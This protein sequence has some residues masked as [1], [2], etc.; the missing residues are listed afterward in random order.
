MPKTDPHPRFKKDIRIKPDVVQ[1]PKKRPCSITGCTGEGAYKVPKSRDQVATYVWVC[2]AHARE[3]NEKWD[4]FKG[5]SDDAV[6][7]FQEDAITGHRPTWPLGKRAAGVATEHG[8]QSGAWRIED[9]FAV[10]GE[11]A[12]EAPHRPHRVLTGLQRQA[13]DTLDLE[14]NATLNEIKAR[15]KEL[16]KRFH[17]DANGGNR[18][19]EERLKQV[20]KAYGVLRA[21]GMVG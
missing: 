10:F 15:Y 17:P 16:V 2:L 7:R 18:G 4:Y 14:A 12:P 3:H 20:I 13:F 9:D 19:T 5:M 21:A 1:K 6:A 8:P 11:T